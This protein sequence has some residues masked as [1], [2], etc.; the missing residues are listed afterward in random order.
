VAFV[1]FLLKI[2]TPV[3]VAYKLRLGTRF[4]VGGV[5]GYFVMCAGI[6]AVL[7][8]FE[9][10]VAEENRFRYGRVYPGTVIEKFS[11]TTADGTRH[12][13]TYG[14]RNQVDTQPVVTITG[15]RLHDQLARLIV[16]G[17]PFAWVVDY[18]FACGAPRPCE[19]RDFLREDAWRQLSTGQAVN[20]RRA[21]G[22][23][24]TSRLDDNPQWPF[25]AADFG[26]GVVLLL[27]AGYLTGHIARF[28]RPEQ[29]DAPLGIRWPTW[30]RVPD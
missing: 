11:S 26:V 3:V 1:A 30:S 28:R 13:G 14:G 7:A 2:A 19:G 12:I 5:T 20:V 29:L 18:R 10:G 22:E 25:A 21:E 16:T 9:V 8:G 4:T 15:F 6:L 17:S 23:T 27:V 24:G